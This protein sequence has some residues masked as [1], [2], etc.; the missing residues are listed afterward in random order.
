M[1]PP[2]STCP[3]ES[4]KSS[5]CRV[6]LEMPVKTIQLIC[7]ALKMTSFRMMQASAERYF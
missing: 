4:K 1:N 7:N 6:K 3:P 5:P 2:P